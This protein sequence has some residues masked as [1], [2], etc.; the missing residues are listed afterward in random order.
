M[1]MSRMKKIGTIGFNQDVAYTLDIDSS[2]VNIDLFVQPYGNDCFVKMGFVT[3]EK[4]D[5]EELEE[6]C[7]DDWQRFIT[8][9]PEFR[10]KPWFV[11]GVRLGFLLFPRAELQRELEGF[12]FGLMLYSIAI[13]HL[14]KYIGDFVLIGDACIEEGTSPEARRLYPRLGKI[15]PQT[16]LI[17]GVNQEVKIP[18]THQFTHRSQR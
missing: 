7:F 8:R 4:V 16:G 1:T 13:S 5:Q 18:T 6:E 2:F 3:F 15:Y 9:Y 17:V 10:G 12:G 11:P 14:Y